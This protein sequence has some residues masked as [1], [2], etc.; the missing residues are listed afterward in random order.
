VRLGS[1][2]G[3][4]LLTTVAKPEKMYFCNIKAFI[5]KKKSFIHNSMRIAIVGDVDKCAKG[6]IIV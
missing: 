2:K 3:R 4:A 6:I 5:M 1:E